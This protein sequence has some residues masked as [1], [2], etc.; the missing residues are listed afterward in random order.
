MLEKR[1]EAYHH[2]MERAM[3]TWGVDLA[4]IDFNEYIYYLRASDRIEQNGRMFPRKLEIHLSVLGYLKQKRSIYGVATS[5][6]QKW[7]TTMY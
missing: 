4:E 5:M 2:F 3:P 7:Y 1:L 6:I